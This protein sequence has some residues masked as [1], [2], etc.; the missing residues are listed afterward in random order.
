MHMSFIN[1]I[2]RNVACATKY[3]TKNLCKF[4]FYCQTECDYNLSS[5]Y[6]DECLYFHLEYRE[7]HEAFAKIRF[8]SCE[9]SN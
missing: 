3:S 7:M 6:S 9:I 5:V 1:A 8:D 4:H 2:N